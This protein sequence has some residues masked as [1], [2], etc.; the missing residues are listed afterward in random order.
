MR[1]MRERG[2]CPVCQHTIWQRMVPKIA[3]LV[4][5]SSPHLAVSSEWHSHPEKYEVSLDR[6]QLWS[7][8]SSTATE[9][10]IADWQFS[11]SPGGQRGSEGH[12]IK[13]GWSM[14]GDAAGLTGCWQ[15]TLRV[16]RP[17]SRGSGRIIELT[18]ESF[19]FEL[20][21]VLDTLGDQGRSLVVRSWPG[22]TTKCPAAELPPV[23]SHKIPKLFG[24][25][26]SNEHTELDQVSAATLLTSQ[27]KYSPKPPA[28]AWAPSALSGV[29]N[30]GADVVTYP[31]PSL[32]E[33]PAGI[34]RQLRVEETSMTHSILAFWV[35]AFIAAVVLLIG[36][37]RRRWLAKRLMP[38]EGGKAS[39]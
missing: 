11:S 20:T 7:H 21:E 24:L 18:K 36:C 37:R 23:V 29:A 3:S 9:M 10:L 16:Q 15:V 28:G 17:K 38:E 12:P 5:P 25:P 13:S 4:V 19:G 26:E 2:L 31:Q 32:V 14:S 1:D 30:Q 8:K 33:M 34:D 27:T 39:V 6:R 22:G 35:L